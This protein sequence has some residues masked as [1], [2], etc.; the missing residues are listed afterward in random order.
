[1]MI[2][3]LIINLFPT[4]CGGIRLKVRKKFN[5]NFDTENNDSIEIE[6]AKF[7][8]EMWSAGGDWETPLL[9]FKCQIKSGYVPGMST[10]TNPFFVFVPNGKQGNGHLIKNDDKWVCPD[11]DGSD[12]NEKARD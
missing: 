4:I 2:N 12:V 9:Y 7:Y 5:V 11:A 3:L 10:S 8:C 6:D 1:M